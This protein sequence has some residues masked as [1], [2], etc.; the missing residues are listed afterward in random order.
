M[1]GRVQASLEEQSSSIRELE[2]EVGTSL[3]A[4]LTQEEQQDLATL[5]PRIK[6]LEV[7][8]CRNLLKCLESGQHLGNSVSHRSCLAVQWPM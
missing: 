3:V 4:Q 8:S 2:G 7:A 6:D 1:C 5:N